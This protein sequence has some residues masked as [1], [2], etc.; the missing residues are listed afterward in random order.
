MA[1]DLSISIQGPAPTQ[2]RYMILAAQREGF[3]MFS[4]LLE[5]LG[6]T[7]PQ[8]EILVVLEDFG[9]LSLR[10]LGGMIVCEAGSPSRV[11]NALVQR[12][13]VARNP[14]PRDR[15]AVLLELTPAAHALV[16]TLRQIETEMD[17]R[18]SDLLE[19]E[20]QQLLAVVLRNLLQGSRGGLALD[21]RFAAWRSGQPSTVS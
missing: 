10:D 2:L 17:A 19:P 8:A 3:R 11:V 14:D 13:L 16:P 6:L 5:D 4:R 18:T 9:P 21:R 20:H 15:R 12:G 7:P 1:E